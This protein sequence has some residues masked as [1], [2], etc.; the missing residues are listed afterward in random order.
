MVRQPECTVELAFIYDGNLGDGTYNDSDLPVQVSTLSAA[1]D[2][3]VNRWAQY[4]DGRH[5]HACAVQGGSVYC[6]GNNDTGQI[7]TTG[8]ASYPTPQPVTGL[9]G[10]AGQVAVGSFSSYALVGGMVLSWGADNEGQLGDGASSSGGPVPRPVVTITDVQSVR[11]GSNHA[12]A[13]LGD[14]S[15]WCWG[16]NWYGQIGDGNNAHMFEPTQVLQTA[17]GSPFTGVSSVSIGRFH[18][19]AVRTDGTAWC[20]GYNAFG[21]LGN[22]SIV[23]SWV[24]VPVTEPL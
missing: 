19:C 14:N 18:T 17:G 11:S 22:S 10:S 5:L 8:Q 13:V 21:Q 12:C 4:S 9:G 6:W 20:W 2:L 23:D 3:A 1:T 24:P 16:Q 7:G 15:I